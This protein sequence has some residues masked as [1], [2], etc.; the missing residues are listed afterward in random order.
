MMQKTFICKNCDKEKPVNIR[1]IV[2]QQYCGDAPCQRARKTEWQRQ[3]KATDAKY[4]VRQQQCVKQWQQN[5]PFHRYMNQYR[6]DHPDYVAQNRD[7]QKVRNQKRRLE[8]QQK[9]V[10]MDALV[11]QLEKSTTYVMTPYQL[12]A[13]QKIVKMDTLLVQLKVLQGDKPA[14]LLNFS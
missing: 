6:Q 10:K 5:K 12:D 14:S 11:K 4:C 7:Q 9:I 1:L 8:Q 2:P 13:S 3:K